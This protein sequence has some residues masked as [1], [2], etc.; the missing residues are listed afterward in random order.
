MDSKNPILRNALQRLCPSCNIIVNI[1]QHVCKCGYRLFDAKRK[2]QPESQAQA[3]I[4]R[5]EKKHIP[6]VHDELH[7]SVQDLQHQKKLKEIE[8]EIT[9]LRAI[10][11]SQNNNPKRRTIM[12]TGTSSR[13][14]RALGTPS[15]PFPCSHEVM[16]PPV[17]V[18]D[19]IPQNIN[20]SP[21]AAAVEVLPENFD[22]AAE[23]AAE[24]KKIQESQ[25]KISQWQQRRMKAEISWEES[26][27]VLFEWEVSRHAVPVEDTKCFKCRIEASIKCED[28]HRLFCY[29]CDMKKH[30]LNPFHDRFSWASG[31]YEALPP[32][33]TVDLNGTFTDWRRYDLYL[34][35]FECQECG[36]SLPADAKMLYDGGYFCSSARKSNTF[37]STKL[38]NNW[39]FLKRN[40][41]GLSMKSLLIALQALGSRNGRDGCINFEA[42]KRTFQ[43]W[44]FM[45]Y[46]LANVQSY[47]KNVCPACHTNPFAIHIDGNK[48]LFRYEKVGRGLRES[49]YSESVF[50]ADND[51]TNHL[52]HIESLKTKN[53][54]NCGVSLWK[55]ARNEPYTHKSLDQTGISLASCRHGVIL[56]MC[57]M[58]RGEVFG[59]AHYLHINYFKSAKY[60]CQDII[61]QY[62]PWALK[63]QEKNKKFT[64]LETKPFLGVLHAKAHAW[65]CQVLYGGRWQHG[66]G[67]TTGEETEQIFSYMSRYNS[68]TKNMLK[69]ERE[70]ELSESS[71]FWNQRKH[72]SL[73]HVLASR[74]CKA[75]EAAELIRKEL[76]DL[77]LDEKQLL[78]WIAELTNLAQS[79]N[80]R[81][82]SQNDVQNG[83]ELVCDSI[84]TKKSQISGVAA[85]SKMRSRYR[86]KIEADKKKLRELIA[87]YNEDNTEKL[88]VEIAEE[89]NFPW[90]NDTPQPTDNVTLQDK[91]N[92]AEKLHMYNRTME[93][94]NVIQLEMKSYLDFYRKKL[95]EITQR[96]DDVQNKSAP[97]SWIIE[98][99]GKYSIKKSSFQNVTSGLTALLLNIRKFYQL[100]LIEATNLFSEDREVEYNK[101][102]TDSQDSED[103]ETDSDNSVVSIESQTDNEEMEETL[104]PLI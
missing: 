3:N 66:S 99:P 57:N 20:E 54:Q 53:S 16:K 23:L 82:V 67:L 92:A 60:I 63:I 64:L 37:F 38:L 27:S 94:Q 11:D 30:F 45:Q 59:Y 74:F 15:N 6:V 100:K 101:F 2:A 96:L 29:H 75:K 7:K 14:S 98:E 73:A 22:A 52:N 79:L 33:V 72:D 34:P 8:E 77:S 86:A 32:T 47:N 39:H 55:A 12:Y 70:E 62:W 50:A 26:R 41:P 51:V 17:S 24:I 43:E 44:R 78:I 40:S 87:V 31:Y 28:C 68:T 49:Y 58:T 9:R 85:S 76:A 5:S 80:K 69:A 89:G 46:E 36:Y 61:C 18:V 97:P 84:R 25:V 19:V 10:Y 91:R 103:S 21:G 65:Y 4:K 90:Y 35:I 83:I 71:F 93:E 42:A 56:K 95:E 88:S 104:F 13:K 102:Q 48:K 1:N 81:S